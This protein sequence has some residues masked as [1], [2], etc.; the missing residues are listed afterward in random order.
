MR[1]LVDP[2]E[3]KRSN[4]KACSGCSGFSEKEKTGFSL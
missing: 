4:Y 2:A 1:A 3:F